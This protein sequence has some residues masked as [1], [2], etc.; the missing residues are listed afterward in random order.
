MPPRLLLYAAAL[1]PLAFSKTACE[2]LPIDD[3]VVVLSQNAQQ[4]DMGSAGCAYEV[5]TPYLVLMVSPPQ[6]AA[7]AKESFARMKQ[8]AKQAGATLKD[9]SEISAGSFSLATKG[10]LVIYVMKGG[11]AFSVSLSNPGSSTPLP[12]LL[13]KMRNVVKRAASRLGS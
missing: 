13:N 9:E 1:A 5:T 8:T 3:A 7:G 10:T 12:D 4:R 11:Q 2:I 6:E